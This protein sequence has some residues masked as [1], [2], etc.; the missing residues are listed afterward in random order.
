MPGAVPRTATRALVMNTLPYIRALA[1]K[2]WQ[3]A[4][5]E[6]PALAHGLNVAAGQVAHPGIAKTFDVP[7]TDL[8]DVL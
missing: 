2:G 8:R 6:D 7:L 3:R 1:S 4:C 5:I